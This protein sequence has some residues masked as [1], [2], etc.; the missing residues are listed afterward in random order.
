MCRSLSAYTY[1]P[2]VSPIIT[3]HIAPFVPALE[4]GNLSVRGKIL[5]MFFEP[6]TWP[7]HLKS[8]VNRSVSCASNPLFFYFPRVAMMEMQYRWKLDRHGHH[9]FATLRYRSTVSPNGWKILGQ[10]PV[11]LAV[12]FPSQYVGIAIGI[13]SGMCHHIFATAK[14]HLVGA[15]KWSHPCII[16]ANLVITSK[17]VAQPD[18]WTG[19][20]V[21][22]SPLFFRNI[23]G[24][25]SRVEDTCAFAGS[26]FAGAVAPERCRSYI[27]L[28]VIIV[29]STKNSIKAYSPTF[30]E[31]F[32][33]LAPFTL[34]ILVWVYAI[35]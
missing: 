6:L 2:L 14:Y 19:Q 21:T 9:H 35:G 18:F 27:F 25:R 11:P 5:L 20:P 17:T 33:R 13:I 16:T 28:V 4:G 29:E 1:H 26:E 15:A 32:Q 22:F 23:P 8:P 34:V 12:G 7:V 10:Y 24:N 30:E 31:P 3:D